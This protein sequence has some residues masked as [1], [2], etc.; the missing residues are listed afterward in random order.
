MVA[1]VICVVSV[2][3]VVS[4]EG[5]VLPATGGAG[6]SPSTSAGG[7]ALDV[8][9]EPPLADDVNEVP[10][11]SWSCAGVAPSAAGWLPGTAAVEPAIGDPG[12][13]ERDPSPQA[14]RAA[15]MASTAAMVAPRGRR[16]VECSTRGTATVALLQWSIDPLAAVFL[17]SWVQC[18][19]V[20]DW[21]IV[22]GR[23]ALIRKPP[24][25][26]CG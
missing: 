3:T 13:A 23:A 24:S 22:A 21:K 17:E 18:C 12:C 14:G 16:C 20:I 10:L 9:V 8:G 7:V 25:D 1:V 19:D 4:T 5:G 2:G 11:P 15:R 26:L 6:P